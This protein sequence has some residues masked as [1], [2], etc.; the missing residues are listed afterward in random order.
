MR[1]PPHSLRVSFR[2]PCGQMPLPPRSLHAYLFFPCG[3]MALPPH[4]SHWRLI[5]P[6][7][8]M[9]LPPHSLHVSFILPCSHFA[10]FRPL[11]SLVEGAP[12]FHDAVP[13]PIPFSSSD[14]VRSSVCGSKP[15]GPLRISGSHASSDGSGLIRFSAAEEEA[16]PHDSYATTRHSSSIAEATLPRWQPLHN[17]KARWVPLAAQLGHSGLPVGWPQ[18]ACRGAYY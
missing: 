12:R 10:C 8:Q 13:S 14:N 9:P 15:L 5:L 6:C 18:G 3:Q 2:L 17:L 16:R 7:G 1:L 4:S 11:S